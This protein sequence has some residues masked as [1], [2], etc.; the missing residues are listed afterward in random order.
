MGRG[1]IP[2]FLKNL[3]KYVRN[4]LPSSTSYS[5]SLEAKNQELD[6]SGSDCAKNATVKLFRHWRVLRISQQRDL[7]VN[8]AFQGAARD[9]RDK[10]TSMAI[11]NT[12]FSSASANL[13]SLWIP[14]D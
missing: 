4:F 1:I 10:V 6:L 9:M 2:S 7:F 5:L 8:E 11:V 3:G 14:S 13:R 12:K